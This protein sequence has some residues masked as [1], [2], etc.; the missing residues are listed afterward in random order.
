[1]LVE[2]SH[3]L[4]SVKTLTVYIS[5]WPCKLAYFFKKLWFLL[6]GDG[7]YAFKQH[8]SSTFNAFMDALCVNNDGKYDGKYEW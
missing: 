2:G 6:T 5:G 8:F 7:C 4:K 1:M 3:Q